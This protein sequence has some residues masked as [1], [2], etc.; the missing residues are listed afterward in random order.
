MPFFD[1]RER[2]QNAQQGQTPGTPVANRGGNTNGQED[3]MAV[4]QELMGGRPI[5]LEN[6]Q[7]IEG[8]LKR[9]TGASLA[10]NGRGTAV[11][12]QL[13]SGELID[14]VK[15]FDGPV[16]QRQFQWLREDPRFVG[17]GASANGMP[18]GYEAGMFDGGGQYPLANVMAPGLGAPFTAAFQKPNVVDD[19]SYQFRLNEGLQAIER[20]AS[21]GGRLA[22]GGTL[23]DLMGWAQDYASTE[24]GK[25]YDRAWNEYTGAFNIFDS[26]RKFL[27]NSLFDMAG[28]GQSAAQN[29]ANAATDI[30]TGQGNAQAAA[31]A[32]RGA[33]WGNAVRNMADLGAAVWLGTRR[34]QGGTTPGSNGSPNPAEPDYRGDVIPR[35]GGTA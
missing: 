25:T 6:L 11:D 8:E 21:A 23:K 20:D 4:I 22:T 3:P 30:T 5:T 34:P 10:L 2:V 17:G 33:M 35:R 29:Y 13:P 16:D 15:G 24:Y 9:R 28:R 14:F 31:T 27:F 18:P 19:P 32:G 26:N 7:S 1:W 12:L